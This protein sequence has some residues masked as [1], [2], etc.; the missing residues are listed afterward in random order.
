[1]SIDSDL[2]L[3]LKKLMLFR[4]VMVTTLLLIATYVEAVS[5]TLLAVNP[6]YFLIG[7]TYLLTVLHALALRFLT[8][9]V[10]QVY[11]QVVGDLLVDHRASS[12]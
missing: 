5:E 7:A 9:R 3:R 12:T 4:L 2:E 6:L 1:M 8:R 10:P 11:V